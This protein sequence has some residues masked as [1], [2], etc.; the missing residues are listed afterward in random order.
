MNFM[1]EKE[2]NE[3]AFELYFC[4]KKIKSKYEENYNE[5]KKLLKN[6]RKLLQNLNLSKKKK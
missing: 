4:N 6:K 5:R 3:K 1:S 2:Y